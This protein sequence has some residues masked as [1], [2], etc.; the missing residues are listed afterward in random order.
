LLTAYALQFYEQDFG[1]WPWLVLFIPLVISCGGNTGNQSATLIITALTN[2]DIK[3][4]DW[5]RVVRRELLMG[6][7]LGAVLGLLALGSVY[8]LVEEKTRQE[9]PNA[10]WVVPLTIL[11]VMVCGA[12]TGTLLP[13]LFQRLGLDPAM[14]SNPFVAGIID[15]LGIVIYMNI[16]YAL[17]G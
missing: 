11:A 16:A 6:A 7:L 4:S 5:K 10:I 9:L 13:L 14:M 8:L 3:L 15:I 17:M 1:N 2:G 12:V